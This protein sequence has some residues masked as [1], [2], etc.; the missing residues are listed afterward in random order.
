MERP[1][2]K[3]TRRTFMQ[4]SLLGAVAL[5]LSQ[6]SIHPLV[7]QLLKLNIPVAWY[8]Q[9]ETKVTYNYC[10][11]C[12]WRCGIVVKTVNGRVQKVDGNPADPKSRGMLC[13]RGQAGPSFM[14]DPDRLRSPMLRTG[15][16]GEGQFKEVTWAEAF[17]YIA[18]KMLAIKDQYGEEAIAFFGH[19][20]GDFWFTD[21]LPGAWGS[22]NAAKPSSALCTSPREEAFDPDHRT[23]GW[24]S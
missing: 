5:S 15:E 23:S 3:I 22:P 16:R 11:L 12:P 7:D 8:K 21:Y 24:R 18:E 6:Q 10:D 4:S 9:G 17:D 1:K 14:Y 20:S 13:A 2:L 19:T